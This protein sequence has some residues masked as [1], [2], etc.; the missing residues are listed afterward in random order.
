MQ[1]KKELIPYLIREGYIHAERDKL[2]VVFISNNL[3]SLK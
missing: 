2:L 3:L 1:L